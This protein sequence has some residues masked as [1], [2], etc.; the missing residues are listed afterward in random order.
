MSKELVQDIGQILN[1]FIIIEGA[2]VI[3]LRSKEIFNKIIII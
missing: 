2:E 1:R 3:E